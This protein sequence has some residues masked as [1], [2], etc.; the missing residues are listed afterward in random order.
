LESSVQHLVIK[1]AGV[2]SATLGTGS[3]VTRHKAFGM[4]Q[5]CAALRQDDSF[6]G[7]LTK[8]ILFG[9]LLFSA[10][11]EGGLNRGSPRSGLASSNADAVIAR[12]DYA[13]AGF[14][15][16]AQVAAV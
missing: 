11:G 14:I 13:I 9:Q 4:R 10:D 6:A 8:N 12:G 3:S 7:V 1:I 2:P 15:H 16:H 5:I